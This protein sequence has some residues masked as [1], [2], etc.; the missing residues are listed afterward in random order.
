MRAGVI[1][2]AVAERARP[3]QAES[4]DRSLAMAT[5]EG[6]LVAV[7]DGL[8]HGSEAADVAKTAVGSLERHASEPIIGQLRHCHGALGG[9]RG[10]VVSLAAFAA[11]DESMTWLGVGN[12]E[13][14][15]LRGGA[16]MSPPRETLL[17]R[18]GVV[19]VHLPSL[20]V[21][22]VPVTRGDTLILAT[23]GVRSD[24]LNQ[25]LPY[26]DPPQRLADHLLRRWGSASDDA[27][28]LVVR[29]LGLEP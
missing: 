18:G 11:R 2:W 28:V 6:A 8:G 26:R 19:G 20:T 24:F 14:L 7:V 3:G 27:L 15:L 10:A 29:Y 16:T 17:L 25:T 13:G 5:A 9:T 21:A 23:D 12:V 1:D 22:L 4:G